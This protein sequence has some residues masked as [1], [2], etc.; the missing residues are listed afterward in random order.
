[1]KEE[2]MRIVIFALLSLFVFGCALPV[3]IVNEMG[4][5][6][7]VE[8]NLPGFSGREGVVIINTTQDLTLDVIV[9]GNYSRSF[10]DIKPGT[11]LFVPTS[12][13]GQE[14]MVVTLRAYTTK[15]GEKVF[16][17]ATS[18]SFYFSGTSY[19]SYWDVQKYDFPR[20]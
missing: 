17:S 1:M 11:V 6:V 7:Q 12:V 18:R 5:R 16:Y 4:R 14:S 15:A 20:Y 9:T 8:S 2:K 13:W 10:G 3:A 19:K